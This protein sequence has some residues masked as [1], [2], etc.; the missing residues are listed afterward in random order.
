VESIPHTPWFEK[1][2]NSIPQITGNTVNASVQNIPVYRAKI[3]T[4]IFSVWEKR[5]IL[6]LMYV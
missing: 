5:K 1:S 2:E 6:K 4:Q 3:I